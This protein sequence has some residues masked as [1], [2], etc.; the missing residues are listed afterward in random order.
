[1]PTT[2]PTTEPTGEPTLEPTLVDPDSYG[3]S[4]HSHHTEYTEAEQLEHV[5]EVLGGVAA[6]I[7]L[8]IFMWWCNRG[9]RGARGAKRHKGASH[10]AAVATARRRQL[11]EQQLDGT[12]PSGLIVPPRVHPA[13]IQTV[14]PT[15][16]ARDDVEI[17]DDDVLR[18]NR[19]LP[20]FTMS[21]DACAA[22]RGS[23]ATDAV[24]LLDNTPTLPRSDHARS[25]VA[26]SEAGPT[27]G[28]WVNP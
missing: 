4:S 3:K 5:G 24:S 27:F 8:C 21:G 28:Y 25:E 20:N 14:L 16:K 23:S 1:M 9:N 18:E 6:C 17:V 11:Q 13:N 2:E 12:G 26:P 10:H 22:H 19:D 7:L 15:W